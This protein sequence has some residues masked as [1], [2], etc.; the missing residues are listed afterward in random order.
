M[1]RSG[2]GL[3]MAGAL[4]RAGCTVHEPEDLGESL[5]PIDGAE[6]EDSDEEREPMTCA[7]CGGD[8]AWV[9]GDGYRCRT[10]DTP[11]NED[12]RVYQL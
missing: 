9:D 12:G 6:D 7:V 11:H 3:T 2:D 4:L 10:C 8:C 5:P 1:I